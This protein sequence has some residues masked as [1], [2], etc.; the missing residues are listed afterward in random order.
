M[1]PYRPETIDQSRAAPPRSGE[2]RSDARQRDIV[3]GGIALLRESG[4]MTAVEYLKSHAIR[5]HVIERVLL[6]PQRRRA[7]A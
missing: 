3:A 4:I 1:S 2:L 5:P 7:S 6:E